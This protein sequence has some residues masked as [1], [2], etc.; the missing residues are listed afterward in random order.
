MHALDFPTQTC[1]SGAYHGRDPRELFRPSHVAAARW[2]A[3]TRV[4][5][6]ACEWSV[7]ERAGL[8]SVAVA[9]RR[10]LVA[11]APH[12]LTVDSRALFLE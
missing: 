11:V 2:I 12:L 1:W 4:G 10:D 5:Q 3:V 9:E 7:E 8:L 6:L